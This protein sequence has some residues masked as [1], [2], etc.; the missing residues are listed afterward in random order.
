MLGTLRR[1]RSLAPILF[2]Q[3]GICARPRLDVDQFRAV[4][5]APIS[6]RPLVSAAGWRRMAVAARPDSRLE[7]SA[8]S[9]VQCRQSTGMGARRNFEFARPAARIRNCS[10][11]ARRTRCKNPARSAHT[12]RFRI[13][14]HCYAS[15]S[16]G[17]RSDFA[18]ARISRRPVKR[19][20]ASVT[21][22]KF[23]SGRSRSIRSRHAHLREFSSARKA[24]AAIP[25][26]HQRRPCY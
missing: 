10:R 25:S 3:M 12:A 21:P 22:N 20:F 16:A 8:R 26:A 17:T 14:R 1:A 2:R 9:L 24:S 4:G 13:G 11:H 23:S 5:L 7:S 19:N 18:Y 6:Y 15:K